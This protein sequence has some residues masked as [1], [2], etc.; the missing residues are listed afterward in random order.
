MKKKHTLLYSIVVI[1]TIIIGVLSFSG[2]KEP[3]IVANRVARTK[4]TKKTTTKATIPAEQEVEITYD[5]CSNIYT[6][7]LKDSSSY[8]LENIKNC[9]YENVYDKNNITKIFNGTD[10]TVEPLNK[11]L[12]TRLSSIIKLSIDNNTTNIEFELDDENVKIEKIAGLIQ[13]RIET[14]TQIDEKIAFLREMA[15]FDAE[16]YTNKKNKTTPENSIP[17]IES[18]IEAL[19]DIPEEDFSNDNLYQALIDVAEKNEVKNGKVLWPVRIAITGLS[20]TPG[21]ATEIAELLGKEET[22]KRMSE[23][24]ENLKAYVSEEMA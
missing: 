12:D 21:G 10:Y 2:R 8:S 11:T 18:A 24:L 3:T 17:L 16:L 5:E 23:S 14:L 4:I 15:A 6:T 20:V 9:G 7:L 1:A 19:S 13:P 22:L